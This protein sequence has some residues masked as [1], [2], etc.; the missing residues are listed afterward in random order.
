MTMQD[1]AHKGTL[2][3]EYKTS[4]LRT[5]LLFVVTSI[6]AFALYH[7]VNPYIVN[8]E[9][10][11]YLFVTCFVLAYLPVS[12]RGTYL[13]REFV[14]SAHQNGMNVS[15]LGFFSWDEVVLIDQDK[16]LI[17]CVP[18]KGELIEKNKVKTPEHVDL[19]LTRLEDRPS[20]KGHYGLR[21]SIPEYLTNMPRSEFLK[22]ISY[23]KQPIRPSITRTP[24][25]LPEIEKQQWKNWFFGENTTPLKMA[26]TGSATV[27]TLCVLAYMF[28]GDFFVM[29]SVAVKYGAIFCMI[30]GIP[31]ACWV[32]LN[33]KTN[34]TLQGKSKFALFFL[35]LFSLAVYPFLLYMFL[36]WGPV[37]IYTQYLG[38]DFQKPVYYMAKSRFDKQKSCGYNYALETPL[39]STFLKDICLNQATYTSMPEAGI[40]FLMGKESPFGRTVTAY[41]IA[42]QSDAK[43]A[44]LLEKAPIDADWTE[45]R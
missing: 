33:R 24:P 14:L 19:F 6:A 34:P 5:F 25:M 13:N 1:D 4:K 41:R 35:W 12:F 26:L 45:Y 15:V 27:I 8:E 42:S 22:S 32:F 21:I 31:S 3:A 16:E 38:K 17:V 18:V 37:A 28:R 40:L 43:D 44:A 20:V 9:H 7:I 11:K 2:I 30:V 36:V 39:F 29:K 23:K 10:H